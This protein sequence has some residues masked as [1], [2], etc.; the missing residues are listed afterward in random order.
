MKMYN[1]QGVNNVFSNKFNNKPKGS[2]VRVQLPLY[3]NL[4]KQ[5]LS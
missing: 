5:Q 1:E 2:A 4:I 3:V